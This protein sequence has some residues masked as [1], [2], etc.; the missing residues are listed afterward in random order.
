MVALPN[1]TFRAPL[2]V[3]LSI[4]MTNQTSFGGRV[5]IVHDWLPLYGGAERVLEQI[6][7][8][9]PQADIFSLIDAIPPKDRGFLQHKPV[10]TSF[11][12]KLPQAKRRY[13]AYLPLMP[14][15]IEQFDLRPYDLVI[16][17][18][19]AVAKGVITGPDQL[20]LCY[21]S[22]PIRYAWDL[23]HQYLQGKLAHGLRSWL[24]RILLHYIRIWDYRTAAGVDHFIANSHFVAR[25]IQKV[26]G[27][28]ATVIYPP[29]DVKDFT[30]CTEKED[31]YV[32]ASR[33]VPYKRVDLI[34][35]A[36]AR[37][38]K[39]RL[40]VIGDG[41]ELMK[42]RKIATPNIQ[43]MGYQNNAVLRDHLQRAKAF[44]FAAEEDFG[45][46]PVEAQACGT[47]VIA[48]GKGGALETVIEGRTGLF[49][50]EHTSE[51]L[52]AAVDHFEM[53]EAAYDPKTIRKS[54]EIFSVARFCFEF[55]GFAD[56]KW[57]EF[58]DM[59][60]AAPQ[61]A[62]S[63]SFRTR[64]DSSPPLLQTGNLQLEETVSRD[65]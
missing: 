23:Q 14:L 41:P 28:T 56:A 27:R 52:C 65:D 44:V 29:V 54:S 53:M 51:S 2:S 38:P 35:S 46:A 13:R 57:Q 10:K 62:A 16:S 24:A 45:I 17:S 8:V 47:P 37:M 42:L 32:T 36:F 30:L 5:A 39:R 9:F 11:I 1:E 21:C 34:V 49:F 58:K 31:F 55:E 60:P 40:I 25:R 12:Q 7:N 43:L 22:S 33:L 15:A 50:R 64:A 20:H 61:R 3:S 4:T 48:Y 59:C 63:A 19:Y 6:L 26:Y 18:S